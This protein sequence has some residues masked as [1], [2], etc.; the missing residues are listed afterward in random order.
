MSQR[1]LG[2]LP[3][4]P[5]CPVPP[6]KPEPRHPPRRGAI[7]STCFCLILLTQP[8]AQPATPSSFSLHFSS[9]SQDTSTSC[10]GPLAPRQPSDPSSTQQQRNLWETQ[11]CSQC[12]SAP[13]STTA[14]RRLRIKAEV[15]PGVALRSSYAKL[16]PLPGV[17]LHHS[18]PTSAHQPHQLPPAH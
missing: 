16:T 14:P 18:P 4:S 13:N 10:P 15:L 12:S 9:P 11:L 6:P 7:L 5:P 2:L 3:K 8:R 1:A 17:I